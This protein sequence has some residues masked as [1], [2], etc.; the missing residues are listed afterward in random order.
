MKIGS[1][2]DDTKLESLIYGDLYGF[3]SLF[4]RIH[5]SLC[6]IC[7]KR[8]SAFCAFRSALSEIPSSEPPDGF[9][10]ALLARVRSWEFP[11][12]KPG[13]ED[14]AG[15]YQGEDVPE[16]GLKG[17]RLRWALGMASCFALSFLQW[18]FSDSLPPIL[19]GRYLMS[20]AELDGLW[21]FVFSGA[22]F[23]SL[24][25]VITAIRV[26]GLAS[27]KIL[28]G[29]VPTQISGVLVFGGIV[30][31]AF[32]TQLRSSRSGGDKR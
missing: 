5:T 20:F 11:P 3:P 4:V 21:D 31:A 9:A 32:I 18:R 24:K 27:I 15:A 10:E 1:C 28:G 6:P 14:L 12:P 19:Q 26:D 13:I 30:T 29:T 22:W 2:P 17:L 8:L 23:R 25:S 16:I 7:R